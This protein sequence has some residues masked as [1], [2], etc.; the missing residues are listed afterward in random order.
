MKRFAG[1]WY[2]I[3][4]NFAIYFFAFPLVFINP[5]IGG[6]IIFLPNLIWSAWLFSL[7]L[8]VTDQQIT[9][10]SI[11]ARKIIVWSQL[12]KVYYKQEGDN[13]DILGMLTDL[14][15]NI[16]SK[17]MPGLEPLLRMEYN[18]DMKAYENLPLTTNFGIKIQDTENNIITTDI[19]FY[20]AKAIK[21]IL[22]EKANY[23]VYKY[24]IAKFDK[25]EDI[26]FDAIVLNKVNGIKIKNVSM[27]KQYFIEDIY[28]CAILDKYLNI[29][30]TDGEVIKVPL[31]HIASLFILCRILVGYI[32]KG[33]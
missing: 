12:K 33:S 26:D 2:L 15:Y 18:Y 14:E 10:R 13:I 29:W 20:N 16:N 3:G 1:N 31:K 17:L 28:N 19:R 22:V 24:L 25:C 8:Y 4:V 30:F 7:R 32:S 23:Y 9:Y 6:L 11:F 21:E 5:N 27:K